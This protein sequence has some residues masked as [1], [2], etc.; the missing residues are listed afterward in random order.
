MDTKYTIDNGPY[1]YTKTVD[2]VSFT[3]RVVNLIPF[4]SVTINVMFFDGNGAVISGNNLTL[5]GQD[6]ND[7]GTDDNYLVNRINK[8][9]ATLMV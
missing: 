8:D 9:I 7:W 6:Y 3:F 5:T 4:S 1:V 2:V